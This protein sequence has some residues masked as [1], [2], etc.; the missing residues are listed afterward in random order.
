MRHF[1]DGGTWLWLVERLREQ[2]CLFTVTPTSVSAVVRSQLGLH[3]SWQCCSRKAQ[4]WPRLNMGEARGGSLKP[5]F[6]PPSR[7]ALFLW[8][9]KANMLLSLQKEKKKNLK[10]LCYKAPYVSLKVSTVLIDAKKRKITGVYYV[11][12]SNSRSFCPLW[13][14]HTLMSF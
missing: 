6:K 11:S 5:D 3:R 13:V 9:R 7:K 8:E 1:P 2:S 12:Q 4:R 10:T 14:Q